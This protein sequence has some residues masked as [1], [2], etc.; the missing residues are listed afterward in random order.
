M[1]LELE[2]SPRALKKIKYERKTNAVN[3]P[4]KY[5]LVLVVN[6]VRIAFLYHSNKIEG[7]SGIVNEI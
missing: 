3:I 6:L 2:A 1:E 7:N 4:Y 5:V